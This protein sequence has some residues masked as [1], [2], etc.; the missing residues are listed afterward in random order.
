M[1]EYPT[2]DFRIQRANKVH[3]CDT[4]TCN[5][6][7]KAIAIGERYVVIKFIDRD[8]YPD[9][10]QT[11]KT[12]INCLEFVKRSDITEILEKKGIPFIEHEDGYCRL[13]DECE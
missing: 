11:H 12:H 6:R 7:G 3:Y 9:V 10:V 1:S 2:I 13:V 5:C 8:D 4:Y